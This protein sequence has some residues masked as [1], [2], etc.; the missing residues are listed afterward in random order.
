MLDR[1]TRRPAAGG[2]EHLDLTGRVLVPGFVD[3][4][5]HGAHS[6]DVLD[7]AGAVAAVARLL[8]RWGVTAFTPTTIACEP[9]ALDTF[10]SEVARLRVSPDAD[11][12]RVL[13]AHLESNFINPDYC[14]A[15]P[16]ACLRVPDLDGVDRLARGR[17]PVEPGAFSAR[18]ILSI[19][20]RHRP[21]VG[22]VTLAPEIEG[23]AAL[24]R[25]LV[26][27]GI[28]VSLGHSGATFDQAIEAIAA[29]ARRATHLFNRMSPLHHR[30]PGLVG[31]ALSSE[32]VAAEIIADGRHVHPAVVRTAIHAKGV[33]RIMAIT[34]GT[35]ASGLPRGSR[36][37]LGGQM[38]TAGDVAR[39]DDGTIAGSVATMEAVLMCL[40]GASGVSL[41]DAIR[42][43]STTPA[44]EVGLLR[45]GAIVTGGMADLV[46][47]SAELGVEQ[48]W[49]GGRRVYS[50]K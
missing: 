4:H 15:Q 18:D 23:G 5:V 40:V 17:G 42:V 32:G 26:A 19:I 37:R 33:S 12:A 35:A 9:G 14:G 24:V 20:D 2:D 11:S 39:L 10:L 46:V 31:A 48:T 50:K 1:S 47:L 7:G 13:P 43:C 44:R 27:G 36:A 25:A 45:H 6:H 29:G 38:V 22:I 30:D 34:D 21:E 49:I 8:P 3:V 28:G 41:V 16:V